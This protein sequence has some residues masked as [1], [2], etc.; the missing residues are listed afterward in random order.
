VAIKLSL[1]RQPRRRAE[2]GQGELGISIVMIALLL[3]VAN[4]LSLHRC[5]H[6]DVFQGPAGSMCD[7]HMSA[8]SDPKVN[9]R[10]YLTI[11]QVRALSSDGTTGQTDSHNAKPEFHG[12]ILRRPWLRYVRNA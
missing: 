8:C 1:R 2:Q 4:D 10:G 7:G 9:T 5:M 3:A 6:R 12:G 11:G